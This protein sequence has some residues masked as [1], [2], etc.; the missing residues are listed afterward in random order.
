MVQETDMQTEAASAVKHTL[1]Q[2]VVVKRQLMQKA[3]LS[4][5]TLPYIYV[6]KLW[7]CLEI[8]QEELENAWEDGRLGDTLLDLL[9]SQPR[10]GRVA[11]VGRGGAGPTANQGRSSP[12]QTLERQDLRCCQPII[13]YLPE[14]WEKLALGCQSGP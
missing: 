13:G 4:R 8:L 11:P 10:S 7:D 9:P 2:T 1:Y 5:L 3:K 12:Q 14:H 6:P